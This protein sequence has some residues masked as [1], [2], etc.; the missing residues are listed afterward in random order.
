MK[1]KTNPINLFVK[2]RRTSRAIIFSD[3]QNY[4]FGYAIKDT[5]LSSEIDEFLKIYEEVNSIFYKLPYEF[6]ELLQDDKGSISASNIP[7]IFQIL[8][9]I[10]SIDYDKPMRNV[11]TKK[12]KGKRNNVKKCI[13]ERFSV[14]YFY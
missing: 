6:K 10:V 4:R 14:T 5:F 3:V 11:Y 9:D 8:C 1:K 2:D 13:M 7:L 12:L